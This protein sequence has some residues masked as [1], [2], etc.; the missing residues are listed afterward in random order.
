MFFVWVWNLVSHAEGG[1]YS[2]GVLG[3]D[4]E[5]ESGPVRRGKR[6]GEERACW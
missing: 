6:G 4:A 3:Y 1:M 5:E 2:E